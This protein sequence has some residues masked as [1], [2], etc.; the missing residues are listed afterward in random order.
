MVHFIKLILISS[1][2]SI[3]DH[4]GRWRTR[5]VV[6][7]CTEILSVEGWLQ[8]VWRCFNHL[9][10]FFPRQFFRLGISSVF[11]F[12]LLCFV[13]PDFSK[14][15]A[16]YSCISFF[17]VSYHFLPRRTYTYLLLFAGC[18]Y[19]L[20]LLMCNVTQHSLFTYVQDWAQVLF[21]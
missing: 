9:T 7:F 12:S 6:L 20:L 19:L 14:L 21:N 11:W 10:S 17:F 18:D 5:F 4:L 8:N 1:S 16:I 3:L 13:L 15:W 2:Y